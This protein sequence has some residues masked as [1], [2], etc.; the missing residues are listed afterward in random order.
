[1][2]QRHTIAIV[3]LTALILILSGS[4]TRGTARSTALG[5]VAP[6]IVPALL[7]WYLIMM[8]V[9]G[10]TIIE[11]LAAFLLSRPRGEGGHKKSLIA[12]IIAW[13]IVI[14]LASLLV[15]PEFASGIAGVLQQ[16]AGFFVSRFGRSPEASGANG[17]IAPSSN[18]VALFYYAIIVF[19]AIVMVSFSLLFASFHRAYANSR[20]FSIEGNEDLRKELI[21]TLQQA[22][23]ELGA[24]EGYH[25]TILKCYKQMCKILSDRGH[26]IVPAQTAREY[27]ENVSRK[28]GLGSDSVR[29]LTFLFEEARYSDHHLGDEKRE[30]AVDYLNS[31][32]DVL[33][34]VGAKA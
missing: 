16:V 27:A 11:I 12:T 9:Y 20:T 33:L 23:T 25:E 10:K 30:L 8:L 28:L 5:A 19:A 22:R 29:G 13:A 1:M 14:G 26:S 31:I 17:T 7:T 21:Q 2:L 18:S 15:R 24:K 4:A 3:G 6:L 34:N 32:E